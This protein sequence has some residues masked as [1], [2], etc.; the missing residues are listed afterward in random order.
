MNRIAAFFDFDGTLVKGDSL[1]PFIG[2][3]VGWPK[4]IAGFARAVLRPAPGHPDRRTAIKAALLETTLK[5]VPEAQARAAAQKLTPLKVWKEPAISALHG[6]KAKGAVIVV[7]TGALDLYI[8]RLLEGLPVDH[9]LATNMESVGGILTGY[10][11]DGNCVRAEKA[12][13]VAAFLKIHG[14]FDETH[15]FGNAPHD[16]P[17][18]SLLDNKTVV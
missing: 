7:A 18:L 10:M 3:A 16:L 8:H 9:V 4:L 14:P 17:M 5:G 1:L 2:F 11:Q 13:R 15:G 6:L 12:R